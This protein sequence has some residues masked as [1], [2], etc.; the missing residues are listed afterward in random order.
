MT[1]PASPGSQIKLPT[2]ASKDE[3]P[4]AKADE[5]VAPALSGIQ[6]LNT[7]T[8][9]EESAPATAPSVPAAPQAENS[10]SIEVFPLPLPPTPN[11]ALSAVCG[12]L[13]LDLVV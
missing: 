13:P 8:E 6:D 12:R 9:S 7:N 5:S 4:A 1:P 2:V 3:A 10:Q 11:V